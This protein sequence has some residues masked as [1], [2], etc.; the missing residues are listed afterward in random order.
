MNQ[1]RKNIDTKENPTYQKRIFTC[2]EHEKGILDM[3]LKTHPD[4]WVV[5]SDNPNSYLEQEWYIQNIDFHNSHPGFN[6]GYFTWEWEYWNALWIREIEY[7][8]QNALKHPKEK[9]YIN[10]VSFPKS[11]VEEILKL[12]DDK[13]YQALRRIEDTIWSDIGYF[14]KIIWIAYRWKGIIESNDSNILFIWDI[15]SISIIRIAH[16]LFWKNIGIEKVSEIISRR[17]KFPVAVQR[18]IL[19]EIIFP[20]K[21]DFRELAVHSKDISSKKE[22]QLKHLLWWIVGSKNR[23]IR[24]DEKRKLEAYLS[25][26]KNHNSPFYR[27]IQE[28]YDYYQKRQ[29]WKIIRYVKSRYEV[30]EDTSQWIQKNKNWHQ[31]RIL[32]G[33]PSLSNINARLIQWF[34]EHVYE[35]LK[36]E[37]DWHKEKWNVITIEDIEQYSGSSSLEEF[38]EWMQW[39]H[40]FPRMLLDYCSA[41]QKRTL[42]WNYALG[43]HDLQ[44]VFHI[45]GLFKWEGEDNNFG[46]QVYTWPSHKTHS[47]ESS[48]EKLRRKQGTIN[49]AVKRKEDYKVFDEKWKVV[50]EVPRKTIAHNLL[51]VHMPLEQT[52]RDE[53]AEYYEKYNVG[54]EKHIFSGWDEDNIAIR[55]KHMGEALNT[56]LLIFSQK[57]NT[58]LKQDIERLITWKIRNLIAQTNK[59][60]GITIQII[61]PGSNFRIWDITLFF[62]SSQYTSKTAKAPKKRSE[63]ELKRRHEQK[64][65]RKQRKE[66]WRY[67]W[68]LPNF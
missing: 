64:I 68:R 35:I 19:R 48:R 63:A 65:K 33:D 37:R 6:K 17:K 25:D 66:R 49:E 50:Q 2:Q 12:S 26:T 22:Q 40:L 46:I 30:L 42:K 21:T 28:M 45:D 55:S 27:E 52:E 62:D 20:Q 24:A 41:M 54:Q 39:G 56:I 31:K 15:E 14:Q 10:W 4:I 18:S 67:P 7:S 47:I 1:A 23:I 36:F 38:T 53:L 57:D 5:F 51:L 16:I 58:K 13:R 9:C 61:E 3:L 11:V 34:R 60:G 8:L 43:D 44:E 59:D 29:I 32:W